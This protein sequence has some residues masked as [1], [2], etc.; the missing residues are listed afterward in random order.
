LKLLKNFT[1]AAVATLASGRPYTAV[2]DS[3]EVNFSVVPGEGFNSF[4][5]AGVQDVDFRIARNFRVNERV[6]LRFSAESFNILNHANFQQGVV[7]KV[8]YTLTQRTDSSGN[9]SDLWDATANPTF[10]RPLAAASRNGARSLQFSTRIS[11]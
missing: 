8:Q 2:F 4:R 10:G 6:G 7:D 9:V 5:D 11:F 1:F 3:S